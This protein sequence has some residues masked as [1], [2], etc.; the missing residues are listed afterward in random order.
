[1]VINENPNNNMCYGSIGCPKCK[2]ILEENF[3]V[4]YIPATIEALCAHLPDADVYYASFYVRLTAELLDKSHK[5]KVIAT[6]S[7]GL[8]HIDLEAAAQKLKDYFANK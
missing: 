5:L 1:M 7:T 6:P 2:K 3:Q 8:D 4:R